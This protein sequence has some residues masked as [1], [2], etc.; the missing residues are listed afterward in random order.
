MTLILFKHTRETVRG[1]TILKR[2]INNG[3]L[4]GGEIIRLDL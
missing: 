3:S 2:A 4:D 1:S